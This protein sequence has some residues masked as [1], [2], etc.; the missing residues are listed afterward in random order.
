VTLSCSII[1]TLVR[2]QSCEAGA[3]C[4]IR[5]RVQHCKAAAGPDNLL[6]LQKSSISISHLAPLR[7]LILAPLIHEMNPMLRANRHD[8]RHV[9]RDGLGEFLGAAGEEN[10]EPTGAMWINIR[11][12]LLPGFRNACTAP[13]GMKRAVPI[14]TST[15]S[16]FLK[17]STRPSSGK[18]HSSSSTW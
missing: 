1:L 5:R 13:F 4:N 15:H 16:L 7:G 12:G 11:S 2:F 10:L 18:N 14:G 17:D 8:A 9:W 6:R 3:E